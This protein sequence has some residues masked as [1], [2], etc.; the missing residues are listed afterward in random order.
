VPGLVQPLHPGAESQPEAPA[1]DLVDVERADGED[2]RASGERP[3]D[4]GADPDPPGAR[5]QEARLGEGAAKEL[6]RPD[7]VEARRLGVA[8]LSLEIGDVTADRGDRD[9]VE[10]GGQGRDP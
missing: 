3:G 6:G 2:E 9:A 1:R 10:G 4:P 7:A 5:G 8:R